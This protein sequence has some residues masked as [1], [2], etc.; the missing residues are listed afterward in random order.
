MV[1]RASTESRWTV[2]T[3]VINYL[4]KRSVARFSCVS[5]ETFKQIPSIKPP[6][7]APIIEDFARSLKKNEELLV[8]SRSEIDQEPIILFCE[9]IHGKFEFHIFHEHQRICWILTKCTRHK[10]KQ[11]IYRAI[12]T[13]KIIKDA[14][15]PNLKDF[16][17]KL[18]VDKHKQSFSA[19]FD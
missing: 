4:P 2:F 17:E 6:S 13:N 1:K 16:F 19:L 18:N 12:E 5:K 11:M 10:L 15:I 9:L 8:E 3:L 14:N 7:Y